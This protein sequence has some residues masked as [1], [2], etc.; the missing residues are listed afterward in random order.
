MQQLTLTIDDQT[1]RN[2]STEASRRNI[3]IEKLAHEIVME[4][5]AIEQ[6]RKMTAA[7]SLVGLFADDPDEV[8]RV[9]DDIMD[10]RARR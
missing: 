3:S 5:L 9:L 6:R 10:V 7:E 8:D 2:L 4:Q 1:Y